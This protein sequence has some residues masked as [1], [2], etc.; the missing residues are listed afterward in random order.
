MIIEYKG[1]VPRIGRNVFLAPTA[2]LI[3][4]VVIGDNSSIWFG[5]V[6]R[7][8]EGQ[9]IVGRETNVQDN[10]VLHTTHENPTRL[11]DRVTIGH[12]ALLEGCHIEEGAVIGMGAVILEGAVVGARS[13]VAARSVVAMN[14]VIPS[15]T[16]AAGAP[17]VVKKQLSGTAR[18]S[19][20]TSSAVYVKLSNQ[21]LSATQ[22]QR[23]DQDA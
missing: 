1:K 21:Y 17:A 10:A 4:D 22:N 5:A 19:V 14:G 12:G 2:T 13:M 3:G 11:D 16:L 6:L 20:E 18:E 9:I 23:D 15:G 7:G 8:D